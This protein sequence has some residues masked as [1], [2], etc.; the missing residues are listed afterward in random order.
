VENMRDMIQRSWALE[1]D[2]IPREISRRD[3]HVI[4]LNYYCKSLCE[5][6]KNKGDCHGYRYTLAL[7]CELC[8]S[9]VIPE[10]DPEKMTGDLLWFVLILYFHC[11][12]HMLY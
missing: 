4:D 6:S 7:T 5:F 2:P 8:P 3:N 10:L 9:K 1:A 11:Y 12:L